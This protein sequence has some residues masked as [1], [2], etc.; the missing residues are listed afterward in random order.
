[1]ITIT[2]IDDVDG[3]ENEEPDCSDRAVISTVPRVSPCCPANAIVYAEE[4]NTQEIVRCDIIVDKIN[5]IQIVTTTKELHLE[6]VSFFAHFVL[7]KFKPLGCLEL[8]SL[9]SILH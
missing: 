6:E 1:M 5:S 9:I 8:T 7:I 4:V 2:Y 3:I